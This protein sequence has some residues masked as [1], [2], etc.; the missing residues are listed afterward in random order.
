MDKYLKLFF[1]Q[2]KQSLLISKDFATK[3]SSI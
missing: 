1:I 2:I 3:T